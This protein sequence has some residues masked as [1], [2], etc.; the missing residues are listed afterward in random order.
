MD[1]HTLIQNRTE[2]ILFLL[3]CLRMKIKPLILPYTHVADEK[4]Q[5]EIG[6]NGQFWDVADTSVR[7]IY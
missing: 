7:C 2:R 4:Y 3:C 5:E 1:C 6:I